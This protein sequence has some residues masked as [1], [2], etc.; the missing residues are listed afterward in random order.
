LHRCCCR[1]GIAVGRCERFFA[2]LAAG[3]IR[4][5]LQLLLPVECLWI[6]M[7]DRDNVIWVLVKDCLVPLATVSS[8]LHVTGTENVTTIMRPF[9]HPN[10]AIL[11]PA[12]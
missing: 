6:V 10:L 11:P 3:D 1:P 8:W 4:W 5:V 9:G 2:Q 12:N 7:A